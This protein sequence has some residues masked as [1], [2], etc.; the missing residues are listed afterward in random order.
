M[1]LNAH[2]IRILV[3]CSL[4]AS[5]KYKTYEMH[6][7]MQTCRHTE[8]V[9]TATLE[10]QTQMFQSSKFHYCCFLSFISA[11]LAKTFGLNLQ[12]TL[13]LTSLRD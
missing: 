7:C 13:D 2:I 5:P 1:W 4:V 12:I 8:S 3:H 9:L 11:I 6:A 10:L